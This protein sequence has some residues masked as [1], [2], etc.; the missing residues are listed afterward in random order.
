MDGTVKVFQPT[1]SEVLHILTGHSDEVWWV[2]WSPDGTRIVTASFDGTARV[3]D[4][5]TGETLL[6]LSEHTAAVIDV[7]WSPDGTR[8]ATASGDGT[9]R[10]WD[11]KAP[12]VSTTQKWKSQTWFAAANAVGVAPASAAC[13]RT[14]L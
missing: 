14:E 7:T 5:V 9:A 12:K 3:W 6:T 11:C 4:V 8:I 2:A 1:T 10:V 13:G